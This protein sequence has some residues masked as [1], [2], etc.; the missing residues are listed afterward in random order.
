[1]RGGE[2]MKKFLGSKTGDIVVFIVL[3][4]IFMVILHVVFSLG[5]AIGGAVAAVAA[6]L[7]QAGINKAFKLKEP[8]EPSGQDVPKEE[9]TPE[10]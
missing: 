2:T 1:M 10:E 7:V 4:V 9:V 6:I 8:S 3:A 5:G